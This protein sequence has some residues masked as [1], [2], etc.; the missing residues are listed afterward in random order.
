[1][2]MKRQFDRRNLLRGGAAL[3]AIGGAAVVLPGEANA[4]IESPANVQV[5]RIFQLTADFHGSRSTQD[6]ELMMSLWADD[7]IFITAA[8]TLTT[9]D[10]IRAFF[11]ASGSWTSHRMAF[12]PTFKDQ[13]D[14]HGDRAWLYL[15]CHDVELATGVMVTHLALFGTLRKSGDRWLLWHMTSGQAPLSVDQIYA[16]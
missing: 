4:Q 7:P 9:K 13:I 5:A 3:A 1:M 11:L 6:I 16:P 8:G 14:V 10:Q 12:A 2:A 15:E